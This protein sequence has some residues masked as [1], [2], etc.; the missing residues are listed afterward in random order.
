MKQHSGTLTICVSGGLIAGITVLAAAQEATSPDAPAKQLAEFEDIRVTR[1]ADQGSILREA[2]DVAAV[3]ARTFDR[4]RGEINVRF[5]PRGR[6]ADVRLVAA[7]AVNALTERSTARRQQDWSFTVTNAAHLGSITVSV[8]PLARMAAARSSVS[9]SA[10][11]I[12][13]DG[14]SGRRATE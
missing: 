13:P 12:D 3:R 8:A 7:G 11:S 2:V 4:P 1:A 6:Q 5:R 14:R 10:G 9:Q